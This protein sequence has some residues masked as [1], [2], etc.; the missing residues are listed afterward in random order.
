MVYFHDIVIFSQ[1]PLLK[2]ASVMQ[3]LKKCNFF[4]NSIENSSQARALR[5]Q[6]ASNIK[7]PAWTIDAIRK[8]KLPTSLTEVLSFI[9]IGKAC[10]GVV[11]N[12]DAWLPGLTKSS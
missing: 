4:P 10:R 2:E 9:G 3:S 6:G 1:T 7:M 11:P 8:L 12:F 5:A